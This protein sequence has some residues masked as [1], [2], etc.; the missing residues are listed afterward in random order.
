MMDE[1]PQFFLDF[2][3]EL[4][5]SC[6][7]NPQSRRM[8]YPEHGRRHQPITAKTNLPPSSI[9]SRLCMG[10]A[11]KP[12]SMKRYMSGLVSQNQSAYGTKCRVF[13][14][15]LQKLVI[16]RTRDFRYKQC[17]QLESHAKNLP[18]QAECP[19]TPVVPDGMSPKTRDDTQEQA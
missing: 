12:G 18:R 15:S 11:R 9:A 10:S 16:S 7:H 3:V 4:D 5:L 8:I 1:A 19:E 14:V 13:R 6:T 17:C 2:S